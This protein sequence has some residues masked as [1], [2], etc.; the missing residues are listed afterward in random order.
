MSEVPVVTHDPGCSCLSF[1]GGEWGGTEHTTHYLHL[2]AF[3]CEKCCGPVVAGW[4]GTRHDHITQEDEI[5][6]VGAVC[7]ACGFR[8]EIMI[9]PL[10]GHR[11]RPVEWEWVIKNQAPPP[12][13]AEDALA[14]ELS[15]DADTV[16]INASSQR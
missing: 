13:L 11:F 12:D 6:G 3:P 15:Q 9:E 10:A 14:A 8:P 2:S 4:L 1:A 16:G 7:L 5:R